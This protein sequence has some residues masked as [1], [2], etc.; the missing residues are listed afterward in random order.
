M[1]LILDTRRLFLRL[2]RTFAIDTVCDVGSLDGSEPALLAASADTLTFADGS[3]GQ[4]VARSPRLGANLGLGNQLAT[5]PAG[6]GAA[7]VVGGDEVGVY[8]YLLEMTSDR[9]M[10]SGFE[11]P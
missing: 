5:I 2:L 8:R 7:L 6:G 3:S 9:L 1:A 4:I 10:Q 11:I